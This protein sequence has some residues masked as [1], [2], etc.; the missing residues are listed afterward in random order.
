MKRTGYLGVS[1]LLL[2]T[3]VASSLPTFAQEKQPQ[4]K[5]RP[6][7]DAYLALFN[8]KDPA[9][10][11]AL[12]EK[13]IADFKE[14]EFIPNAHTFIIGAYT[15]SKNWAKVI[16]AADRAAAIPNAET[17]L[18]LYAYANAMIAAQNT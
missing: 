4:A 9:K 2:F 17:K 7:Y 8:E 18:K 6:E 13:F 15:N 1:L 10:K 11:A 12:G 3:L 5:T 14:S 16:E